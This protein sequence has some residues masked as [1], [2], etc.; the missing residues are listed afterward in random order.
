MNEKSFYHLTELNHF[1]YPEFR[2]N[3]LQSERTE[4]MT[5]RSYPGY[6]CWKLPKVRFKLGKSLEKILTQRRSIRELKKELP[7]SRVL[8]RLLHFSH[9]ITSNFGGGSVPSAGSLQA[10]ELYLVIWETSWIPAGLYHYDRVG[11]HLSQISAKMQRVDWEPIVPSLHHISG[12]SLLWVLVGD[13]ERVAQKYKDRGY[14]F[15]LLE[16]GHLM[17]N[18]CLVSANLRLSTVPLGGFFEAEIARQF[19]LPSGD[20]VAYVGIAGTPVQKKR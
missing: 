18:L 16:A 8:G 11:H 4:A 17:Q 2:E 5:S 20:I 3:V 13:G 15:L 19:C 12:G 1:N 9:G 10:L 7:S 6:P 14:R